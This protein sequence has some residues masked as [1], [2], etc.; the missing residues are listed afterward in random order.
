MHYINKWWRIVVVVSGNAWMF[1]EKVNASIISIRQSLWNESWVTS[2]F[3]L[4]HQLVGL[5]VFRR[6][7]TIGHLMFVRSFVRHE[8]SSSNI[9]KPVWP[10]ITK[11]Y[12]DIHAD[13]IYSQTGYD[14]IIF[15]V[16]SKSHKRVNFLSYPG[17]N[18]SVMVQP[19][20]KRFTVLETVIQGL[21]F[22]LCNLLDVFAPWARKWGSSG[23]TVVETTN[24]SRF[25]I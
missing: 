3:A 9:S 5:L 2:R 17:R 18:F 22:L 7:K 14:V 13:I 24:A 10:R 12:E 25:E 6:K 4:P 11:F 23:P 20:R 8:I 21:H 19:I 1:S 16:G 15:S